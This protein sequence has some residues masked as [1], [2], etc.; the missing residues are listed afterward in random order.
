MVAGLSSSEHAEG[1][2]QVQF[3]LLGE[4]KDNFDIEPEVRSA[5]SWSFEADV[6]EVEAGAE[7]EPKN[8]AAPVV[9]SPKDSLGAEVNLGPGTV[10]EHEAE[11]VTATA[12]PCGS[13]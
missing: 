13:S 10:D 9:P 11:V 2:G 3:V 7:A 5:L 4:L 12:F 1:A 6:D 8:T